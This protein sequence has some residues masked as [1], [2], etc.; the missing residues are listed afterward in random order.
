MCELR[1]KRFFLS[2]Y[3][4]LFY[5]GVQLMKTEYQKGMK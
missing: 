3:S 5:I 2:L 1:E 4:V